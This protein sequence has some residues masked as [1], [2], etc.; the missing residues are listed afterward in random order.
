MVKIKINSK[1]LKII[2]TLI[3]IVILKN[4]NNDE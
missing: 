2:G 4:N 1:H 3:I